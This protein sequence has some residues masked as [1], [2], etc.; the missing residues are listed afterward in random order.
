ME[1]ARAHAFVLELEP[2]WV[3]V[4]SSL[5]LSSA[6]ELVVSLVMGILCADAK[7]GF[8]CNRL[9]GARRRCDDMAR[10]GK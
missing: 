6:I 7:A 9:G 2:C 5:L 1:R 8:S 4:V 10:V 3:V